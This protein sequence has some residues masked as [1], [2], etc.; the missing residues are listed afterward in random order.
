MRVRSTDAPAAPPLWLCGHFAAKPLVV[1]LHVGEQYR[2]R[3]AMLW[4]TK[5]CVQPRG[6]GDEA[7]AMRAM[8]PPVLEW[9]ARGV[10]ESALL[11]GSYPDDYRHVMTPL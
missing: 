10:A 5:S 8:P 2:E 11:R 6:G 3:R 7:E 1:A 9:A 4:Q